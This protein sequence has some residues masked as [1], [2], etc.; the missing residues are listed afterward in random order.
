MGVRKHLRRETSGD[1]CDISFEDQA[2]FSCRLNRSVSRVSEAMRLFYFSWAFKTGLPTAKVK[3]RATDPASQHE[4]SSFSFVTISCTV[5]L[6]SPSCEWSQGPWMDLQLLISHILVPIIWSKDIFSKLDKNSKRT[7][8]PRFVCVYWGICR[9]FLLPMKEKKT[10]K[11]IFLLFFIFLLSGFVS[12]AE[13]TLQIR[14]QCSQDCRFKCFQMRQELNSCAG[15]EQKDVSPFLRLSQLL[16]VAVIS[17]TFTQ[18]EKH[19]R[20]SYLCFL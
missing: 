6:P 18:K 8:K 16:C 2:N 20:Q 5:L 9:L 7:S 3:G 13:V 12:R 17:P 14:A 10:Q 1:W 19:L 4:H 15:T 11:T